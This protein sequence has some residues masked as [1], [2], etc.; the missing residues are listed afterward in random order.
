MIL[1]LFLYAPNTQKI[2][3]NRNQLDVD[4]IYR[5]F[6]MEQKNEFTDLIL[7]DVRGCI[8]NIRTESIKKYMLTK[9]NTR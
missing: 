1:Q 6:Y 9:I 2:N 7:M 8:Q 3:N 4:T 5:Y